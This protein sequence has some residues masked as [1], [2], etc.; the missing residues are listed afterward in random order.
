MKK[1]MWLALALSLSSVSISA[2]APAAVS[3]D[4][5]AQSSGSSPYHEIREDWRRQVITYMNRGISFSGTLVRM[6]SQD[7]ALVRV[8]D[9]VS[10]ENIL[11]VW[12]RQKLGAFAEGETVGVRG[13]LRQ[14]PARDMNKVL[15]IYLEGVSLD[16]SSVAPYVMADAMWPL[17]AD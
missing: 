7:S 15:D 9:G 12:S 5:L 14:M 4:L 6:T 11:V 8:D 17:D 2:A 13:F 1:S 16:A 10:S 3:Q